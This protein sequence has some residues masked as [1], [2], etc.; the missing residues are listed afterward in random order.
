MRGGIVG[1]EECL[2]LAMALLQPA[3]EENLGLGY[4]TADG[5]RLLT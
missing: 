1:D 4:R 2:R 3:S 5:R